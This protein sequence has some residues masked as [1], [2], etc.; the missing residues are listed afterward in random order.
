MRKMRQTFLQGVAL[1]LTVL[2][3]PTCAWATDYHLATTGDDANTGTP[4]APF[5]TLRKGISVL[6]P[7]D[8]L[9]VKNGTYKGITEYGAFRSG[10]SWEQPVKVTAYPG[11]RPVII[12]PD[13]GEACLYFVDT[14]YFVL[15]GF[16]LDSA[17]NGQGVGI[18]W[19]TGFPQAHHIELR[20]CEIKNS[21][22]QGILTGGDGCRFINLDVHDNGTDGLTHGIYLN[23]DGNLI[24]GGRYYRNVGWGIHVYPKATNTTV[25]NVRCFE[26]GA[27]GLGLVWGSNNVAYNN[28]VYRN[29]SGIH[30]SGDSPR[31]YNNTV[32][33]NRGEGLSVANA[34]NGPR[35][36]RKAD[37]RNNIVFKNESEISDYATGTGTIL[38]NNFTNDPEFV[39]ADVGDFRLRNGSPAIDQGVDLSGQGVTT[40][41]EGKPRPQDKAFDIGASEYRSRKSGTVYHVAPDGVDGTERGSKG[42]PFKTIGYAVKVGLKAGDIV[43]VRRGRYA[44]QVTI[45]DL[46]GTADAPITLKAVDG[47]QT[48]TVF[49]QN[50]DN[51]A[52]KTWPTGPAVF[53][54]D[55]CKYVVIDGFVFSGGVDRNHGTTWA[56]V[57]LRNSSYCTVQNCVLQNAYMGWEP[58]PRDGGVA[59]GNKCLNNIIRDNGYVAMVQSG[60]TSF[61]GY[62]IYVG[63]GANR[64]IVDGCEIY[65]NCA[66]GL[67]VKGEGNIVRNCRIYNNGRGTLDPNGRPYYSNGNYSPSGGGITLNDGAGGLVYNNLIYNNAGWG[68]AIVGYLRAVIMNNTIFNNNFMDTKGCGISSSYSSADSRHVVRNNILF[69]NRGGEI[70]AGYNGTLEA[71]AVANHNYVDDATHLGLAHGPTHTG[72]IQSSR[73]PF[74]S[75]DPLS[76]DFLKPDPKASPSVVD[77]GADLSALFSTDFAGFARPAGGAW[78]IGAFEY[79][80]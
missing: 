59:D 15:D 72:T 38:S 13:D 80:P 5:S 7:G 36:T 21:K 45:K 62:G 65:D 26:N 68:I 32:Y 51:V 34:G 4:E 63:S 47:P 70:V 50:P 35:G 28:V 10:S 20:N 39:D 56:A 1:L 69:N 33:G 73:S 6:K 43:A 42:A 60:S 12:P 75:S 49:W 66:Y 31:C 16:I 29:G 78:D 41:I 11:H 19:G 74:L 53:Q 9:Y 2:L 48:A 24:D 14:K 30:L 46:S 58:Y 79:R 54:I 55:N 27:T 17:P 61:A 22:G 25:R 64:N 40:D 8:T 76:P 44:E 77:A 3:L 57:G 23:G 18:T 71:Y 52:F 67:Q 37:V